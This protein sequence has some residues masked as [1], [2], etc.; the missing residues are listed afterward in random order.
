M[1][2]L[3]SGLYT[4]TLISCW[5][6][7]FAES[8][9][10]LGHAHLP[11]KLSLVAE[12]LPEARTGLSLKGSGGAFLS[13]IAHSLGQ[14]KLDLLDVHLRVPSRFGWTSLLRENVGK[15]GLEG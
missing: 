15:A 7:P 5:V 13:T 9:L 6:G 14:K 4:P 2:W 3:K 11:L 12:G 10:F 8:H 1:C